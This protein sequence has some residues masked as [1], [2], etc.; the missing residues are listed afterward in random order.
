MQKLLILSDWNWHKVTS[1]QSTTKQAFR[2]SGIYHVK[3]LYGLL[4][5]CKYSVFWP[6]GSTAHVYPVSYCCIYFKRCWTLMGYSRAGSLSL[7]RDFNPWTL[8]GSASADSTCWPSSGLLCNRS[9]SA[10]SLKNTYLYN[11]TSQAD[12]K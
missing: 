10:P 12:A 9:G 2:V 11:I 8:S 7:N 6:G 1:S 4:L 5:V 3:V